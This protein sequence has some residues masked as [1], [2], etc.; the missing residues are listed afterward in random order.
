MLKATGEGAQ[1]PVKIIRIVPEGRVSSVRY[2]VGLPVRYS[3]LMLVD[4]FEL[5]EPIRGPCVI[6]TGFRVFGSMSSLSSE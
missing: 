4:H 3:R 2:N 1:S 5:Y 6:N